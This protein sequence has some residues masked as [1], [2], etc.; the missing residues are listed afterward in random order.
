MHLTSVQPQEDTELRAS[1]SDPDNITSTI[2]WTWH[3]RNGTSDCPN[4]TNSWSLI[5]GATNSTY[6]PETGDV[7]CDLR[8]TASYTD[9][10]GESK[11]AQAISDNPVQAAPV[12]PNEAPVFPSGDYTREVLEN[13][14]SGR[15]IGE[16]RKSPPT[17]TPV[18]Y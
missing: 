9:G 16:S 11:T 13:T 10:Y 7:D 17:E 1:A 15:D 2:T 5:D 18:T 8:A 14:Q 12:V 3:R 4:G 6:T